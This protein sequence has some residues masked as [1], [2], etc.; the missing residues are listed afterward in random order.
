MGIIIF[1]ILLLVLTLMLMLMALMVLMAFNGADGACTGADLFL[2][3]VAAEVG[4]DATAELSPTLVLG[5][6]YRKWC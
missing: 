6:K 1:L 4:T 5:A 3:D 2:F